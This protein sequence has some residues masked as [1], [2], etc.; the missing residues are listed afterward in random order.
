M[1]L[2]IAADTMSYYP[3]LNKTFNIYTDASDYQ[4][5][6]AIIQDG[7]PIAYWSKKLTTSQ[8]NYN[9]IEKE[10]SAVVLCIKE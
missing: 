2:V 5:G 10:L 6:A 7:R 8:M 3:D 9:T 4:L 1:K